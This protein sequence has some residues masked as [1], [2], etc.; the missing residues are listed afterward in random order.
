MDKE[1]FV[2]IE[3]KNW[4]SVCFSS[5]IVLIKML[6]MARK[7]MKYN[8]DGKKYPK[9]SSPWFSNSLMLNITLRLVSKD[10]DLNV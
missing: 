9:G 6:S 4:F 7:V 3:K 8:V 5:V 10:G 1:E 2:I